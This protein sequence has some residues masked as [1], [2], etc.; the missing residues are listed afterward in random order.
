MV[1]GLL[2]LIIV[3]F[4][5]WGAKVDAW[6]ESFLEEAG[7]RPFL[8]AGVL[9]GLLGSDILFPIPSSIVSTG[10]GLLLGFTMGTLTSLAGMTVSCLLGFWLGASGGR[11]VANILVGGEGLARFQDMSRKYG[12]W[13]IVI[14][15]PVPV[16]AEVSVLFAGMGGISFT[17]FMLISTLSNLGVSMVYA[18]IGAYSASINSFLMAFL[19]GISVPGI[20]MLLLRFKGDRAN[21]CLL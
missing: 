14:A 6:T 7:S 19:A 3:P 15:R 4:M 8:V 16:L 1:G 10:C 21:N 20:A 18:A 2:A 13:A 12:L 11:P 5:I 17:R 9:G